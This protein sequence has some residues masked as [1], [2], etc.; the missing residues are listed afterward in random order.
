M[1]LND[2]QFIHPKSQAT[3][4]PG[5]RLSI[6]YAGGGGFGIPEERDPQMVEE[7]LAEELISQ[8]AAQ[9]VYRLG[10]GR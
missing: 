7:D 8:E 2:G 5:D 4:K 3:L 6:D 10:R 9:R 1:V